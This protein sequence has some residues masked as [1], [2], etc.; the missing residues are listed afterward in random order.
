M[1]RGLGDVYKRQLQK[2]GVELEL[3]G[4]SFG[5]GFT[6]ARQAAKDFWLG[7][8]LGPG[9]DVVRHRTTT[10]GD[11]SLQ[12]LPSGTSVRPLAY[13]LAGI[14]SDFSA[15][16]LSASATLTAHFTRTHYD[17]EE[18]GTDSELIVPWLVQPGLCL[19]ASWAGP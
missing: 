15:V 13:L 14:R 16:S 4:A 3:S 12:A 8:E 1:S 19:G 6:F 11:D 9:L 10:L 2:D 18:A 17:I 7:V 5:L